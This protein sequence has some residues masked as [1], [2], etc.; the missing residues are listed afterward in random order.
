MTKCA[1]TPQALGYNGNL[2]FPAVNREPQIVLH[3]CP[4]PQQGQ[5]GAHWIAGRK[6]HDSFPK[7]ENVRVCW[8]KG[9]P[10]TGNV[11]VDCQ[12]RFPQCDGSP[13]D[14]CPTDSPQISGRQTGLG[15]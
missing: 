8:P 14:G 1:L 12:F 3:Q 7:R 5:T 10:L 15:E 2:S 9:V 6:G 13:I 4:Q 11:S